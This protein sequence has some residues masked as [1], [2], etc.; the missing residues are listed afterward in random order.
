MIIRASGRSVFIAATGLLVL[1]A[2]PVRAETATQDSAV[3]STSDSAGTAP[4]TVRKYV[5]HGWHHRKTYAQHRSHAVAA[6]ADPDKSDQQAAAANVAANDSKAL[7]DMPASV[8]NANAQMLLAG[9]QLSAAAAIPTGSD[10]QQAASDSPAAKPDDGT[11]VV[12]A[13]QLNDVD[14]GL[15]EGDQPAAAVANP[16]PAQAAAMTMTPEFSV[17]DHTSL[18][19]KL[20]IGFGALLTM[21][22]A[23][24]MFIA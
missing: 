16:P 11:L 4:V 22:S 3:A 21:A 2:G 8:A 20:F 19:G 14:R 12:A 1:C 24:R 13:D 10:V 6:K 15:R 9:V 17:W 5:R 18:I 7:A 23:A